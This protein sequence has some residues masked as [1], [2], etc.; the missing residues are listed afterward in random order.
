MTTAQQK[1][2]RL[3]PT[4]PGPP[5]KRFGDSTFYS[6]RSRDLIAEVTERAAEFSSNLT[7]SMVIDEHGVITEFPVAGLGSPI[8]ALATA[9]G[10]THR[11]HRT[12]VFRR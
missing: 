7:A 4:H 11:I 6:V 12:L 10:D 8:R 1:T 2:T 5:I 9:D 3:E